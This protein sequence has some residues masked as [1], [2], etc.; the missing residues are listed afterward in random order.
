MDVD[1]PKHLRLENVAAGDVL[2]EIGDTILVR[3]A[4][5]V[6]ER[7]SVRTRGLRVLDRRRLYRATER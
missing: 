5:G 6:W 7:R 1:L 3:E 2:A 4:D